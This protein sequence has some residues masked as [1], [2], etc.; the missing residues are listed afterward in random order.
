[1]AATTCSLC[2]ATALAA[3]SSGV[4][5]LRSRTCETPERI[6]S[7]RCVVVRAAANDNKKEKGNG[8][9][10]EKKSL[11]TSLTDALDFAAVRSEKDAELLQDARQATKSGDRMSREQVSVKGNRRLIRPLLRNSILLNSNS[12]S[13]RSLRAC[14]FHKPRAIVFATL[15]RFAVA[16][17][18]YTAYEFE[19]SNWSVII[20]GML[21][22]GALRRKIGGTY[23]DFFKDSV[24]GESSDTT[25]LGF[26]LVIPRTSKFE[27]IA[28]SNSQTFTHLLFQLGLL[29]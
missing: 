10:E 12:L 27:P 25:D 8:A 17:F 11:F 14:E 21:Q 23:R 1:M 16:S 28:C 29:V 5:G 6:S 4:E 19:I 20:F 26:S 7:R 22:Y 3:S 13:Q 18:V 24:E 9:E 2:G 15:F